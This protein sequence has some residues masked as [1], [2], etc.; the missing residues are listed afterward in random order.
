[1]Y[2]SVLRFV[3]ILSLVFGYQYVIAGH[4]PDQSQK[5]NGGHNHSDTQHDESHDRKQGF[6]AGEMI[7]HH[8][9]DAHEIHFMTFNENTENE[10]HLT[11]PLPVILYTRDG[12]KVFSFAN[13]HNENHAYGGFKYEHGKFFYYDE[14]T[15]Q[16]DHNDLP[17][18]FSITK[19]VVGIFLTCIILMLILF[20]VAAAYRKRKGQAPRGLQALIEMIVIFVRDEIAKPSIGPKYE[21]Y[22]PYL[23]SIFFFIFLANLIGL[24]PF[25][26]GFNITGNIAVT[27]VLAVFT[28]LITN[29]RANANYWAHIFTPPGIPVW[30][31]PILV[32]IEIM[33]IFIKPMVLMLR[34]FANM[35][36]GHIIILSFISLIFIF[37]ELY[38]VGAAFGVSLLSMVFAIFMN[39]L[40]LLVAFLQAFVFTLL[41]A[42]YFGAS[43]EEH[44]HDHEEVHETAT[45]H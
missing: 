43:V 4:E 41:S 36:A 1:M 12:L 15:G 39:T 6:N 40:E 9:A 24:I 20:P 17:L 16:T 38:G 21:R 42:I 45:N 37:R 25:I 44:H 14:V 8:V 30:L 2:P 26:G 13:F 22:M 35:T 34:L 27:M 28:F 5:K 19:T 18:D 29:L 3:L 7:M 33:G 32:P 11:I 31:Y 10:T 23:L